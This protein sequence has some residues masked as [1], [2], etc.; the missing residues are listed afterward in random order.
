MLNSEAANRIIETKIDLALAQPE[1]TYILWTAHNVKINIDKNGHFLLFIIELCMQALY[2]QMPV[3]TNHTHAGFILNMMGLDQGE[4]RA[5][6]KRHIQ[7]FLSDMSP[8]VIK[9]S[10]YNLCINEIS[11]W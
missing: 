8:L 5:I 10:I 4:V 11:C 6:M 9:L 1:G 7:G 2:S 3:H